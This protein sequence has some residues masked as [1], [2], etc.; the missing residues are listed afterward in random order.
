[1]GVHCLL[2]A[3]LNCD[4][5]LLNVTDLS[6]WSRYGN[7]ASHGIS[8]ACFHPLKITKIME[9]KKV[10]LIANKNSLIK[11]RL[12]GKFDPNRMVINGKT[13]PIDN[14][15]NNVAKNKQIKN[16]IILLLSS[17]LIK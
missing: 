12:S 9:Q 11:V 2:A 4:G 17:E 10:L 13:A 1:M 5:K 6:A 15:S 8:K 14:N 7:P 3:H 16:K